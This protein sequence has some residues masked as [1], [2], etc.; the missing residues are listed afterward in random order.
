MFAGEQLTDVCGRAGDEALA[1]RGGGRRAAAEHATRGDRGREERCGRDEHGRSRRG[2]NG[3]NG[4]GPGPLCAVL[5]FLRSLQR[6]RRHGVGA[7]W[8]R[9]RAAWR[10][11]DVRAR[12]PCACA[13]A[14][15]SARGA[16]RG[17]RRDFDGGI[18]YGTAR[19]VLCQARAL[20][21]LVPALARAV[22]LCFLHKSTRARHT[23]ATWRCRAASTS[24][25]P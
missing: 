11:V 20:L 9:A 8:A 10:G 22:F 21:D 24:A 2:E 12:M 19:G 3:S 25:A 18:S 17:L 16:G 7:A 6:F 15:L 5:F 1:P 13:G 14:A 23:R 4:P